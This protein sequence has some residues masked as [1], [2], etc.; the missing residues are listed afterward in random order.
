MTSNVNK[1]QEQEQE[2]LDN[3][4]LNANFKYLEN[5]FGV[6]TML[7]TIPQIYKIKKSRK[8]KDFS[9][10]FM[11]GM[12]IINLLFL[13][14]GFINSHNGLMLGSVFFI[15]YNITVVYYYLFGIQYNIKNI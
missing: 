12:I 1:E 9:I 7:A 2:S 6:A 14:V 3:K 8:A 4:K 10:W 15:L 13:I 5:T 11:G